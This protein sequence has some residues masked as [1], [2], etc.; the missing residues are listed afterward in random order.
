MSGVQG[1]GAAIFVNDKQVAYCDYGIAHA[2][3][4]PECSNTHLIVILHNGT[5][6]QISLPPSAAEE[7]AKQLINPEPWRD[8]S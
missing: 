5:Q 3:I 6:V 7:L 8:A 2:S 1:E 4:C